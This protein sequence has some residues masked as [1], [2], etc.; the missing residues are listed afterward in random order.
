MRL[1]E[2]TVELNICAQISQNIRQRIVWFG[3]TQIQEAKAG[4]DAAFNLNGRVLLFQFKASNYFLKNG[5]KRFLL[6]HQ[7]LQNLI[8]RVNGYRRS[9]F[10]LFP[11]IGNTLE[12]HLN[13]GD[14]YNSS[15][16]LDVS[17]LPNPFP[18]PITN[19][20]PQR[21]RKNG[22]HYA[23]FNPPTITIHS[24]PI[25]T[26]LIKLSDL[27]ENRFAGSDGIN[28]LLFEY[29]GNYE[30]ALEILFPFR[31]DFKMAILI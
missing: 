9:I 19:T 15:W 16:V 17:T 5:Q 25:N 26:E 27:V 1:S 29:K 11:L 14:F 6:E 13:R 28:N 10:Y 22:N 30:K 2:K 31:K 21:F 24:D 12:L 23:D 7:Q 8:N 18:P 20:Y 3:L 4:F